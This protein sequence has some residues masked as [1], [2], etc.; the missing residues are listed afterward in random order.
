MSVLLA[1]DYGEKRCGIAVSDPL[2]IIAQG[3]TTI[4]TENLLSFLVDFCKKESVSTFVIGYPNRLNNE[5]SEVEGKILQFIELLKNEF[6]QIPI[7]RI[8]ERFTSKIAF[9][10]MIDGGLKKQQRK[11]KALI[12]QISATILLQDYMERMKNPRFIL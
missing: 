1:I 3:L 4:A 6:P 12:D 2:Q 9:R 5:P 11:N 10:T 8:D 7:E